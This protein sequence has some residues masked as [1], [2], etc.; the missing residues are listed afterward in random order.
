MRTQPAQPV[1]RL[2]QEWC[3]GSQAAWEQLV[4]LIYQELHRL[5]QVF[6]RRERKGHSLQTSELVHEAY[7]RL[8][9]ARQVDW[10]N[11]AHFFAVSAKLMRRILV[12]FARRHGCRKCGGGA[13]RLGLDEV[14][15]PQPQGDSNML[16][17]DQ[18]LE[19]LAAFEPRGAQ[20]VE[21]RFFGGLSEEEVAHVL[22]VT[23]RTVKRDWAIARTWLERELKRGTKE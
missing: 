7:V 21:L 19:R 16:E 1:T 12:D 14:Q 13:V 2:L 8:I 4:P 20:V 3:A 10:R 18:A 15:I 11:R 5:A 22:G 17:I 6:M 9:D 23:S